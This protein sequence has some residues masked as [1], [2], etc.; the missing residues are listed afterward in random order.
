MRLG[1]WDCNLRE[2]SLAQAVYNGAGA[3]A[4]RHRHRYEF[5]PEFRAILERQGLVFS[6]VSPDGK[7]VEMVELPREKHPFFIGCQFHPEYKSKPL[8]A[9]PLFV[10]FVKAAWENR[11]R[12]ENLEHDISSDRHREVPERAEVVS[13]E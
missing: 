9:H 6:G 13:E 3:I 1:S 10:S 8:N 4:E 7:F 11:L 2:G 12:S 5:N